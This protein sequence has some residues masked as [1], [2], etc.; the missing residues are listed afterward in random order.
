MD[1]LLTITE[2]SKKLK[3]NRNYVYSLINAGLL[4]HLIVGS[5][6]VRKVALDKFLEKYE[7]WDLSDPNNPV[8]MA[9]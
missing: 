5:K 8:Q 4:P 1:E 3:C 6:K 7:G 2:V 9:T